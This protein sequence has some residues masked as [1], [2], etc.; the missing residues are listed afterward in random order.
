[1]PQ[2]ESARACLGVPSAGR[3]S[4][5]VRR[6]GSPIARRHFCR[7][8]SSRRRMNRGRPAARYRSAAD[9]RPFADVARR[10]VPAWSAVTED[11][12]CGGQIW[13]GI[14]GRRRKGFPQVIHSSEAVLPGRPGLRKCRPRLRHRAEDRGR[15]GR[16]AH[17]RQRR[18][19]SVAS[20]VHAAHL[21]ALPGAGPAFGRPCR[22]AATATSS[23]SSIFAIRLF[24]EI[25][26]ANG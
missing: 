24:G 5:S 1:M 13:T 21:P 23:S 6:S 17:F 18:L 3:N 22:A 10:G 12:G 8:R 11:P 19:L 25:D 2:L 9:R 15:R 16:R 4:R 26:A 14:Y 7:R 20:G